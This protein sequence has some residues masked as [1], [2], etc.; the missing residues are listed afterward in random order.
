MFETKT[1]IKLHDTDA[2]GVTFFVSHFRIAHTAYE[3]FMKSVGCSLEW[4]I[5]EADF[6]ILIAHAEA[7]YLRPLFHGDTITIRLKA[8]SVSG[9]SFT[10]EYTV[11]DGQGRLAAKLSMVHVTIAKKSGE[12]IP[13]PDKVRIGLQSI[14]RSE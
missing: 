12:K 10:L 2:A 13:L 14:N 3:A 5:R 7:D 8:S 6:I 11:K 4:I 1:V 9:S